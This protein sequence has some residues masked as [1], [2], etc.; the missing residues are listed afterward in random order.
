MWTYLLVK[1]TDDVTDI[2]P[3]IHI[4][5]KWIGQSRQL[6]SGF[7]DNL[8]SARQIWA[9]RLQS[10]LVRLNASSFRMQSKTLQTQRETRK[11]DHWHCLFLTFLIFEETFN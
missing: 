10:I 11:V 8:F 7:W 6:D 4:E 5:G 3:D 9:G 2:L 1:T